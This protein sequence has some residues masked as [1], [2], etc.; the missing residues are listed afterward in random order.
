MS[1]S[2]GEVISLLGFTETIL[3]DETFETNK[4]ILQEFS[5]ISVTVASTQ[6]ISLR[7][8]FSN[9]AINFDYEVTNSIG[10]NSP[11]TITSVVVGKWCKIRALNNSDSTANVRLSTYCSTQPST[12]QSSINSVDDSFQSINIDNWSTT[13]NNEIRVSTQTII[14]SHNFI[15][16]TVN[17]TFDGL[18]GPD[19]IYIMYS[20]GGITSGEFTTRPYITN[21][22][23]KLADIFHS[24]LNSYQF[25]LGEPV[26]F[27]SGNPL[28]V[29]FT[30]L[31]DV[32]GYTDPVTQ[33]DQMMIGMGYSDPL[34]GIITDGVFLGYPSTGIKELSLIYYNKGVESV[35]RQKQWAFDSLDG[36]GPSRVILD[37]TKLSVWRIRTSYLGAFSIFIEMHNPGDNEWI[38]V[39]RFVYENLF[40]SANFGNPSFS[41]IS[42]T[43]RTTAQAGSG[44][45]V[46]GVGSAAGIVGVESGPF[47]SAGRLQ[48]FGT[49]G[50]TSAIPAGVE[51]TALACRAGELLNGTVNRS[52]M[53]F[54]RLSV[55]T[56]GTKPVVFKIYVTGDADFTAPMWVYAP[57]QKISPGQGLLN[58]TSFNVG[59]G[60]RV[61]TGFLS[62]E[63][64]QTY[65]LALFE[66][67]LYATESIV[68]TAES[69][70]TTSVQ[71]AFT[72]GVIE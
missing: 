39:H 10:G 8:S 6:K 69:A 17:A 61:F 21:G 65:G 4:V 11:Q 32:S 42:Y 44:N 41:L 15:Y 37:P 67:V 22:V 5:S 55:S 14:A 35:I 3:V 7:I 57:D 9:D 66:I 68:V 62:K 24:P 58:N 53:F 52:N 45:N 29:S 28:V 43:K 48:T 31:F 71:T 47:A 49:S 36:N 54:M 64:S 34:T 51:T 50:S 72:Y 60:V 38:N 46:V 12:V 33:Y 20:G 30:A 40:T 25:T 70:N 27:R 2:L 18:D 23:L 26:N 59:S 56:D 13:M 19:R 1:T 16:T 63:G